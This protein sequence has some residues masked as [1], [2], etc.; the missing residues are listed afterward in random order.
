MLERNEIES[1]IEQYAQAV[2]RAKKANFDAI[3]FYGA[4]GYLM[5]HFM[6]PYTNKRTDE[7]GGDIEGRLRLVIMVI[8]RVRELVGDEYPLMFRFSADEFM[9]GGRRVEESK[10]VAMRLLA[11]ASMPFTFP[12]GHTRPCIPREPSPSSP[13]RMSR[14]GESIWRRR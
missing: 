4:H 8:R 3:E 1:I 5:A 7:Y 14:A 13:W 10:H 9:D 2:L 12:P 6:S 11:R